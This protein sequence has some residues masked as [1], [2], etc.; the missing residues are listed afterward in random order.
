MLPATAAVLEILI[1]GIQA[2]GWLGL[3]LAAILG[4]GDR[5]LVIFQLPDALVVATV[6]LVAYSLGVIV[7]RVAD[8]LDV[9]FKSKIKG[10]F[11]PIPIMRLRM[12]GLDDGKSKFL[13]YQR[14]RLRIARSTTVNLILIGI[15]AGWFMLAQSDL[16]LGHVLLVEA[17]L[18]ALL[19][20]SIFASLRIGVAYDRRLADAYSM[21][22]R[23]NPEKA[24]LERGIRLA[25]IETED[26][27]TDESESP[28]EHEA[29]IRAAAVCYR[30]TGDSPEFLL[31][32]TKDG[33]RWTFA[34]G[35]PNE[36]ETLAQTAAREAKEEA[37]AIGPVEGPITTYRYPGDPSEGCAEV[38]V[39]AFLLRVDVVR[40]QAPGDAHRKRKWFSPER[41][42]KKLS[43][44]RGHV[45]AEEHRRVIDDAS[46]RVKT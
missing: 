44:K 23:D 12:M 11:P 27:N 15:T 5:W 31:V 1:I 38:Q 24:I 18:L 22:A 2:T 35:R 4:G 8:N 36:G 3:A 39:S 10:E 46:R 17:L 13:E 40:D 26:D 41:A 7:D 9:L 14:S 33:K 29:C 34:K 28:G 25:E 16:S 20:G 30:R 19:A 32:Q 42:K 43:I 21:W 45:Y 37:G 6:G